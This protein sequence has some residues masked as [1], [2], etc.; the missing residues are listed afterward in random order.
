MPSF[1]SL[2]I[3]S[4]VAVCGLAGVASAED[5]WSKTVAFTPSQAPSIRI[6]E[7]AI[8]GYRVT[9][10]ID[11]KESTDTA[12][13][14]FPAPPKDGFY[15][16]TFVAPS[17]ATWTTKVEV[18]RY[19]ATEVRVRHLAAEA[20]KDKPAAAPVRT[21]IGSAVNKISTCGKKLAGRVEFIDANGR[22]GGT[23]DV[24]SGGLG[25]ASLPGG[26]YDV[27]AYIWDVDAW[28]YQTTTR[29]QIL[30]DNWRAT[31]MCGKGPLEIRF[32]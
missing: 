16:A 21:F 24:K 2:L 15:T 23:V 27:R 25:Q 17:G 26:T 14:V 19:Q 32:D 3:P 4:I 18:K 22:V 6:P 31:L 10:S 7:G 1:H 28:T 29:I 13:A 5:T 12:P 30:A 20:P 9:I 8:D 11:G